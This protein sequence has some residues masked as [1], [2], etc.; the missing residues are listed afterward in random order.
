MIT[1]VARILI[2]SALILAFAQ[3]LGQQIESITL[4]DDVLVGGQ[5]SLTVRLVG[6]ATADRRIQLR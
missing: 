6:T 2:F 3:S 1:N 4:D 5:S